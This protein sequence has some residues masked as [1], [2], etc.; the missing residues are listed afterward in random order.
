MRWVHNI[1]IQRK[2][3]VGISLI[4]VMLASVNVFTHKRT[5]ASQR[6]EEWVAHTYEVI[7]HASEVLEA[8]TD[9]ETGYRG[10]L[11]TGK[12]EFLAP[13]DRGKATYTAKLVFLREETSDNQ[14]QV[15]RWQELEHLAMQWQRDVT[16]PGIALRREITAERASTS[17][18]IGYVAR[19][20][21]KL[22]FDGMRALLTEA[23]AMEDSLMQARQEQNASA[24][25][26]MLSVLFWGT[27]CAVLIGFLVAVLLARRIGR[28]IMEVVKRI[29]SL[30]ENEFMS[31]STAIQAISRGDLSVS[32]T[33]RTERLELRGSDELGKV[34]AS[35]ND[36]I[37]QSGET[38]A[39]FTTMCATLNLLVTEMQQLIV[40]AKE[41]RLNERGDASHFLGVYRDIFEGANELL[42]NVVTPVQEA[43]AVLDELA[44]YNLRARVTTRYLGD[45][46]KLRIAVNT[47]A[48]ALHDSVSKVSRIVG[49]MRLSST[50][51]A[52]G[53][54]SL[55]DGASRQ[56]GAIE[57]YSQTMGAIA[58]ATH[59]NAENTRS[60]QE[61]ALATQEAAERGSQSMQVMNDSMTRIREASEG[62]AQIIGDINK[63]AFQTNLLAL[64]AS[65]E[66]ARA[67]EA[68]LGFAAVAE[69][70]QRVAMHSQEAARR[71]EYLIDELL[72]IAKNGERISTGVDRTFAE[73]VAAISQVTGITSEIAVASDSQDL[74]ISRVSF[75]MREM[76][77]VV[78]ETAET[79]KLS[80]GAA[81][82]L[83][84]RVQELS[85]LVSRFE[86]KA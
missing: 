42:D 56:A 8:L 31:L 5:K 49:E 36:I 10:F 86:L 34:A 25:R 60:A 29:E 30:R 21:G 50:Q 2:L 47:T 77:L 26:T 83:A 78:R 1:S 63:L 15:A 9:M 27:I 85:K 19:G 37:E 17:A 75:T 69:E 23:I 79:S 59:E 76:Q 35:L 66:A 39:S 3:L 61:L 46:A 53:A 48:N 70:V 73:I 7:R 62:T 16:E 84:H 74:G 54:L 13:Y 38:I 44:N 43:T 52:T 67:G 55:S 81:E 20:T 24:R 45:H 33:A 68:G 65:I 14:G 11:V 41:G 40:S 12:D 82:D 71:T 72:T 58:K 18:M 51:I 4:L 32:A 57:E 22:H 80:S 64:N 6:A 28:P